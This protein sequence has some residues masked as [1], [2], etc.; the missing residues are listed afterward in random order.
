MIAGDRKLIGDAL[1]ADVDGKVGMMMSSSM[2]SKKSP[3]TGVRSMVGAMVGAVLGAV[4][5]ATMG[6]V[7][8]AM[9]G[10]IGGVMMGAI[11]GAMLGAVGGVM[12]GATVGGFRRGERRVGTGCSANPGW[13]LRVTRLWVRGVALTTLGAVGLVERDGSTLGTDV[14]SVATLGDWPL[15]RL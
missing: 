9:M 6:S 1:G 8:G 10:A 4:G 3:M 2:L 5:G 14:L 15:A 12:I 11:G 13:L 7:G